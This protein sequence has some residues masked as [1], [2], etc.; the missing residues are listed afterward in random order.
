[1]S[2][3]F[4]DLQTGTRMLL[5]EAVQADWL[6]TEV[7][8]GVNYAYHDLA[9][10]VM[11]TYEKYFETTTPFTYAL[12]A[13]QQ[14]YTID[15]SLI[16]VTRV[17]V[18]FQPAV[19]NSVPAKAIAIDMSESLINISNTATVNFIGDIGYYLH[20]SLD[21][22]KIGFVP[23]PTNSDT[24]P[25][26]SISVWGIAIPGD[27][28]SASDAPKIPYIDRFGKL[29]ELEAASYLLSKG[30]QAETAS[31]K[32]HALY[33]DGVL[34]MKNFLIDRQED[35]VRMVQDVYLVNTDFSFP[36]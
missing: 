21:A 18:N 7:K 23:L 36:L 34:K 26:K 6:D 19:T 4:S 8:V 35:G 28:T 31:S 32:Y 3:V 20:G 29:I 11:N 33:T 9:S 17:E 16:K 25:T 5:D 27:M 15:P 2:K 13:N 14:E 12:V 30:Q 10:E 24:S 1:M 22:Q